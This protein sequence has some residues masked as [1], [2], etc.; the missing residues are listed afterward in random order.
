MNIRR[1]R[2]E[3]LTGVLPV[4]LLLVEL[5]ALERA[6]KPDQV[7]TKTR[8]TGRHVRAQLVVAR[9]G[10]GYAALLR[11]KDIERVEQPVE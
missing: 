9:H 2:M 5:A 10:G 4:C 11:A 6:R 1:C 3:T 8:R 7:V